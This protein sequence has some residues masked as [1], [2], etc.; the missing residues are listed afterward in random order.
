MSDLQQTSSQPTVAPVQGTET[1]PSR[2]AKAKAKNNIQSTIAM[3]NMWKNSRREQKDSET[4]FDDSD[5]SSGYEESEE[6]VEV[7]YQQNTVP[8]AICMIILILF[9]K[10]NQIP[11]LGLNILMK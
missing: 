4:E 6:E 8:P 2:V 11:L 5:E 3:D 9:Q 10:H 1:S 7:A